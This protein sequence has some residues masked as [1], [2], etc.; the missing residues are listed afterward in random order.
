M[1]TGFDGWQPAK[2]TTHASTNNT[3]ARVNLAITRAQHRAHNIKSAET[4]RYVSLIIGMGMGTTNRS[5]ATTLR[6][7]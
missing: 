7:S 3:G 6:P 2:N 1:G 4:T 5:R